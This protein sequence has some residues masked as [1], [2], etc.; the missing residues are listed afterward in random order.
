M[1]LRLTRQEH[2]LAGVGVF[3]SM[4]CA[5]LQKNYKL[6]SVVAVETT[7]CYQNKEALE[8]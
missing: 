4:K 5:E 2:W 7:C 6:D 1:G 8:T 3:E